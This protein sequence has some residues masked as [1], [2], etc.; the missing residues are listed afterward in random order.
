MIISLIILSMVFF[1]LTFMVARMNITFM[2]SNKK[3]LKT[4]D[5]VIEGI[6][7]G[8]LMTVTGLVLHEGL[9]GL[10]VGMLISLG[11]TAA[12]ILFTSVIYVIIPKGE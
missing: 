6:T 12:V 11:M 4:S 10:T 5:G 8:L 9:G 2:A 7:M 1:L 3:V